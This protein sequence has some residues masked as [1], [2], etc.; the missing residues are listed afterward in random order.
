[1]ADVPTA[2]SGQSR[3]LT[4][5]RNFGGINTAALA[6]RIHVS[7][8]PRKGSTKHRT[9]RRHRHIYTYSLHPSSAPS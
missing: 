7:R 9:G 6:D 8:S 1:M 5:Y 3:L 4:D 2:E